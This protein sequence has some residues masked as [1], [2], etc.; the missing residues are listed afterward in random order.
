[1]TGS[2]LVVID[3]YDSFTYNTVQLFGGLGA[4]CSVL[5]NDRTTLREIEGLAPQGIVLSP[6][7]GTPDEAGITLAAIRHFSGRV[8]L[9]GICLGHQALAQAFGARVVRAAR[10]IHGKASAIEHDGLGIFRGIPSPTAG[11]RYNSLVVDPSTVPAELAVSA[12]SEA[13]EVMGLRHRRLPIESV[14]FHPESV[15]SEHGKLLFGNWL[16]GLERGLVGSSGLRQSPE[17]GD[18]TAPVETLAAGLSLA[19]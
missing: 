1:M 13:S 17:R 9:L 5:L 16:A 10:P 7:P 19:L 8:P 15:L 3:N 14:Q 11:G 18:A 6:G 2:S 4:R 12:R